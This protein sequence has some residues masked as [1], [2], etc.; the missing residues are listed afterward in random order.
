MSTRIVWPSRT[1]LWTE[2]QKWPLK[3]SFL[4]KK[5][6]KKEVIQMLKAFLIRTPHRTIAQIWG[7][8]KLQRNFKS[9]NQ[10]EKWA[11]DHLCRHLWR[12]QGLVLRTTRLAKANEIDW[13]FLKTQTMRKKYWIQ[14]ALRLTVMISKDCCIQLKKCNLRVLVYQIVATGDYFDYLY[15]S[16]SFI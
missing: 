9:R 4:D 16:P 8:W 14:R 15:A 3:R 12:D 7:F 5:T 10:A 1:K 2:I 13:V 11:K 6:V